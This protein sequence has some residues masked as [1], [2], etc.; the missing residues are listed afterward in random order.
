MAFE[1]CQHYGRWRGC[2]LLES[3][4]YNYDIVDGVVLQDLV[5]GKKKKKEEASRLCPVSSTSVRYFKPGPHAMSKLH[6]GWSIKEARR[7][8]A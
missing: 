5:G 4:I 2:C 1:D 3:I 7:S 6:G 8:V